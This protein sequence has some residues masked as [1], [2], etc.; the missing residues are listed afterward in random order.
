M[1]NT[2]LSPFPSLQPSIRNKLIHTTRAHSKPIN[3]WLARTLLPPVIHAK[4]S[5]D[6]ITSFGRPGRHCNPCNNCIAS[7]LVTQRPL[8]LHSAA[9]GSSCASQFPLPY[10]L[11]RFTDMSY[12]CQCRNERLNCRNNKIDNSVG[13]LGGMV[14]VVPWSGYACSQVPDEKSVE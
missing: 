11:T 3:A 1:T 10:A 13:Q 4:C 7:T 2:V 5:S 6:D 9:S 14:N 12:L 8:N